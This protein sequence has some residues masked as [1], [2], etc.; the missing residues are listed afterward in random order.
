MLLFAE[1]GVWYNLTGS[2]HGVL[3]VSMEFRKRV[4]LTPNI[5]IEKK[6]TYLCLSSPDPKMKIGKKL[7]NKCRVPSNFLFD[8]TLL[9]V[10]NILL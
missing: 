5:Q 3:F 9:P 6:R 2:R 7:F 8:G 1:R 4:S 10:T